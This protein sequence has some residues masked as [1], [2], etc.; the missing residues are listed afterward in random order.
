MNERQDYIK[1]M[2][3]RLEEWKRD[4]EQLETKADS[5]EGKLKQNYHEQI[6]RLQQQRDDAA[7]KLEDLQNSSG[8]A[9]KDLKSGIEM[10]W[11]AMGQAVDSAVKR[12]K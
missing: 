10:A 9:W 3:A 5:A 2:K 11:D 4:I 8:D 7:R 6:A 1:K 12:F